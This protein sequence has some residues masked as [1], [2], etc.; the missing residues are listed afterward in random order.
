MTLYRV[1]HAEREGREAA[2]AQLREGIAPRNPYN[3]S[4]KAFRYWK[5]GYNR[6]L[7]LAQAIMRIGAP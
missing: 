5:H 2:L 3:N 1:T 6:A 7:P 4:S